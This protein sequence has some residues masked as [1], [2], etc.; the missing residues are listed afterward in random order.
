MIRVVL[1]RCSSIAAQMQNLFCLW[2]VVRAN[3]QRLRLS[4]E[5]AA[6]WFLDNVIDSDKQPMK[7]RNTLQ[8]TRIWTQTGNTEMTDIVFI[9]CWS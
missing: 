9:K 3:Q 1:A 5:K 2:R 7:R 8:F 4:A 6:A